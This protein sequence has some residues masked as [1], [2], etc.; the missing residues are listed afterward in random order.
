MVPEHTDSDSARLCANCSEPLSRTHCPACGQRQ[1]DLDRPFRDLAAEAMESFLS[2][3]TRIVRTL[4]PLIRRPGMLTVKYMAGRRIRFAHPFKLYFAF[5]A[6]LF[7]VLASI[8]YTVVQVNPPEDRVIT[9]MRIDTSEEQ[10]DGDQPIEDSAEQTSLGRVLE[11]V[12]HLAFSLHLHSFVFLALIFGLLFDQTLGPSDGTGPGNAFAAL[13]IGIYSFL[14][15]RRVY[16][17]GL[18]LTAVKMLVLLVGYILA[19]MVTMIL[20]LDLTVVAV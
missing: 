16:G 2:F 10:N 20:T 17:Q 12:A 14:A 11:K 18:F 15:L 5:S 8:G 9:G 3:D 1:V 7:L 13:V 4:W 6:L 19:L